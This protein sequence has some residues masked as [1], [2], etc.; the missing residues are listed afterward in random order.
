MTLGTP[1]EMCLTDF[2]GHKIESYSVSTFSVEAGRVETVYEHR[3]CRC[4]TPGEEIYK[5]AP[6]RTR[7]KPAT[8]PDGKNSNL[9]VEA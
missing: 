8:K 1:R 6:K 9:T 2:G 5:Q 4:W 7:S 3:C